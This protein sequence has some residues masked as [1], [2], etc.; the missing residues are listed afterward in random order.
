MLFVSSFPTGSLARTCA[1][2]L[3]ASLLALA[4]PLRA[5]EPARI[6][7]IIDDLGFQP[8]LDAA[9]LALDARVAVA[10]IPGAPAASRLAREA[11]AQPRDVL[12][13]LPLSHSGSG[14]C[15][16]P[17]CPHREWSPERMRRHLDWASAQVEGAVGLNN[18]QGSVFT[19]D[20]G[21][22]RRLVE[23]LVLLNEER[24][25]PL[26][27]VDSRTTPRSEFA[28]VARS[29]GL[30]VGER[31]VFLDHVRTPEAIAAAWE[32]LLAVATTRGHAIAI[33]HPHAQTIDFLNTAL[34]ALEDSGVMLVRIG[35]LVE[36]DSTRIALPIVPAGQDNT[37]AYREWATAPS[38]P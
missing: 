25:Q 13:H 2:V 32:H 8:A 37:G 28:R 10:I 22:S 23:G 7:L 26:F 14:A 16:A 5:A 31:S 36:A 19:A 38:G 12:I 17:I 35:E 30:R 9:V 21:A 6:A 4:V 29:V 15:D 27:V 18:H 33:G 24:E 1:L 34:P 3:A 20:L 11:G